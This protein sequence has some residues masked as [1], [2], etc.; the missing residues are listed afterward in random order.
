M[1]VPVLGVKNGFLLKTGRVNNKQTNATIMPRRPRI[2]GAKNGG[3]LLK[4]PFV[5]FFFNSS[6]RK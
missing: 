5:E 3:K 2:Q 6:F 1:F 4:I